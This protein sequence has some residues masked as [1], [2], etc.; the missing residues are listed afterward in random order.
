MKKSVCLFLVLALSAFGAESAPKLSRLT[1]VEVPADSSAEFYAVQRETA[2][3][4]KTNKAPIARL[5]WTTLTGKS[6]LYTLVDIEGLDKL[7]EPTWLS[8]QGEETVRQSRQA[9]LRKAT[10]PSNSKVISAEADLMWDPTPE[11]GPEAY[12]VVTMYT[13]KPGKVS[14]FLALM[15]ENGELTKKLGKAKCTYVSRV[16]FG[17]DVYQFTIYN[18]YDSLAD[19]PGA[20]AARAALGEDAYRAFWDKMG[21]VIDSSSRDIIRYRPEYSYIPSK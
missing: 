20:G 6:R 17:G 9:R 3:V 5:A 12:A 18:G 21:A 2:E 11:G 8:K 16:A 1:E 7:G 4:Y 15:K 13:V 10:G 14:A 19:I